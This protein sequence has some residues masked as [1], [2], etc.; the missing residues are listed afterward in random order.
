MSV[1]FAEPRDAQHVTLS[2]SLPQELGVMNGESSVTIVP[3]PRSLN[4][5][6]APNRAKYEPGQRAE[7]R[8]HVTD[9][10][11]N[12]VRTQIGI[13]V[14]DAALLALLPDSSDIG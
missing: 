10:N 5:S 9:A 1:G 11:G 7:F 2:V 8:V 6:I 4:V 12:P 13:S 3:A 14:V